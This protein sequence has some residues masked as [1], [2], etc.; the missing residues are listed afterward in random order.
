MRPE[1]KDLRTRRT[2]ESLRGALLI[3][4]QRRQFDQITIGDVTAEAQIGYAT[5]FRHYA[6]KEDLFNEIAAEQIGSLMALVLPL[7]DATDTYVASLA[8]CEYACKHRGLWCTLLTGGAAG[9]LRR[10][11]VRLAKEGAVYVRT[12][13]WL[14]VELGAVYGVSATLEILAWWLQRPAEY[15]PRQIA[16]ILD[17]LVVAPAFGPTC[18]GSRVSRVKRGRTPYGQK[19]YVRH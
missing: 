15:T 13:E 9:T 18:S 14:P 5:F 17:R 11:F 8:L 1:T 10:E 16:E 6:S 19:P 7:L 4:L 2:R 3:L 12:S